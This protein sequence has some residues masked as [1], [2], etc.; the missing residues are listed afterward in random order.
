M[1]AGAG[2][3]SAHVVLPSA[4][5]GGVTTD[6]ALVDVIITRADEK[7]AKK[8]GGGR[9]VVSVVVI[10]RILIVRFVLVGNVVLIIGLTGGC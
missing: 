1:R 10:G 6:P 8:G 4:G 2:F 9:R 5:A 7:A 3:L